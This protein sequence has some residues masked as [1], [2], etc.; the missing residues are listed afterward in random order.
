MIQGEVFSGPSTKYAFTILKPFYKRAWFILLCLFLFAF[1]VAFFL[2]LRDRRLTRRAYIRQQQLE[3]ELQLLRSQINPHFLFNSFNTLSYTI[4]KDQNEAVE[5]V[6]KLSDYFRLV[7]QRTRE[8][9]ITLKQ[10]MNLVEHYLFLQHKRFGASLEVNSRIP[11][12]AME[13]LI[14]PMVIQMLLEN[15]VKH[16]TISSDRKL[17]VQ[18]TVENSFIVVSNNINPL[19]KKPIGTGT[20]LKN[21]Q[22]R[23]EILMKRDFVVI[24]DERSFVVKIPLLGEVQP[25]NNN[26]K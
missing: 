11:E 21:I 19:I 22:R 18:I 5:Y 15:A 16:N 24:E 10:E 23:V 14:P 1:G 6:E 12:K 9:L 20:G 25:I 17:S 7:L 3:G 4:E 13:S 26:S 2:R 8:P